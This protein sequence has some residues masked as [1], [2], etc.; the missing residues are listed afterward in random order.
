M[1]T[2]IGDSSNYTILIADNPTPA[3]AQYAWYIACDPERT[4]TLGFLKGSKIVSP[5]NTK[6]GSKLFQHDDNWDLKDIKIIKVGASSFVTEY[7]NLLKAFGYWEN[8]DSL[9]YLFCYT[10]IGSTTNLAT[11]G[12]PAAPTTLTQLTGKLGE[13]IKIKYLTQSA[14]VSCKFEFVNI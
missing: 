5:L 13:S 6:T 1:V 10:M 7:Q 11:Y 8:N 12:T 9:L 2:S 14:E 4:L 3:S